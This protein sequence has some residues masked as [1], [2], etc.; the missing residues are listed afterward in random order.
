[1]RR[2]RR[3]AAIEASRIKGACNALATTLEAASARPRLARRFDAMVMQ[4]YLMLQRRAGAHATL[5]TQRGAAAG[6]VQKRATVL[7]D[8]SANRGCGF[9]E[10]FGMRTLSDQGRSGRPQPCFGLAL[11]GSARMSNR[12]RGSGQRVNVYE[13]PEGRSR[14]AERRVGGF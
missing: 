2:E 6:E 4:S 5:P 8:V 3:P 1:M 9:P 12:D 10:G 13:W 14:V 7:Q 11:R